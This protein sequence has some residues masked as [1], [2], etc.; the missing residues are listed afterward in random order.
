MSRSDPITYQ[1]YKFKKVESGE[2]LFDVDELSSTFTGLSSEVFYFGDSRL[3]DSSY[4]F[5]EK[6]IRFVLRDSVTQEDVI[7]SLGTAIKARHG[8]ENPKAS[9]GLP[10]LSGEPYDVTTFM[11]IPIKEDVISLGPNE[12]HGFWNKNA[13]LVV[14]LDDESIPDREWL[15]MLD[16]FLFLKSSNDDAFG[17]R[18]AMEERN[19]QNEKDRV[20]R[21]QEE[22]KRLKSE[23]ETKVR[24]YRK[25]GRQYGQVLRV[26][27]QTAYGNIYECLSL[28]GEIRFVLQSNYTTFTTTGSFEMLVRQGPPF[29]AQTPYGP[30]EY[31]SY[32][33]VLPQEYEKLQSDIAK[34]RRKIDSLESKA[35]G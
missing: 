25:Y 4:G 9:L 15:M 7:L 6:S 24:E 33:E 23:L 21:K 14:L 32:I 27:S 30:V 12:K 28:N 10:D 8:E 1:D 17:F 35:S 3:I 22:L 29:S 11:G 16:H 2:P 18:K 31:P 20:R 5:Y 26:L 19:K 34:L 13:G